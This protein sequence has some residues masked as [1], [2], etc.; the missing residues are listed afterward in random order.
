MI[1]GK[2][3]ER[4]IQY[5]EKNKNSVNKYVLPLQYNS[6][7]FVKAVDEYLIERIA[8]DGCEDDFVIALFIRILFLAKG[9]PHQTEVENGVKRIIMTGFPFWLSKGERHNC[10]WS[11]NHLACY[12]SIW[13]L[14]CQYN[15]IPMD[16]LESPA[17]YLDKYLKLKLK[18]GFFECVSQVYN[19][20]T[21]SALLNI[22]DFAID[23]KIRSNA[24]TCIQMLTNHF[25]QVS[26]PVDGSIYCAAGR[27]YQRYKVDC[28]GKNIN[29]Y[30]WILTG[31]PTNES[32]L[33]P[34]GS[35]F[36]SSTFIPT[37]DPNPNPTMTS[38]SVGA[39][40]KF[41]SEFGKAHG[42]FKMMNIWS[43]GNYFNADY[44][45]ETMKTIKTF[46]LWNHAHFKMDEY[47][48]LFQL[49][50]LS[51]LGTVVDNLD[52]F[53][54]GSDL[55]NVKYNIYNT[56]DYCLTSLENYNRGKMGAQ[57]C[58]WMANVGGVPVFTQAG[59]IAA[60][61]G[62]TELHET[63]AN[64]HLPGVYQKRNV[65][66][67]MYQPFDMLKK[68]FSDLAVYLYWDAS[69]FDETTVSA[70]KR[71]LF[72]CKGNSYIG[73]YST[74]MNDGYVN[75]NENQQGWVVILGNKLAYDSFA[76]FVTDVTNNA[77][78]SFSLKKTK[79]VLNMLGTVDT[80]Y[81]GI[82][83]Y[84]DIVIDVKW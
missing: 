33:S 4:K 60:S 75:K 49:V 3:E 82:V 9:K 80:Y 52:A 65:A 42:V 17:A 37:I 29:K 56:G 20:Y 50:P 13:Y 21:M 2:V 79:S 62:A 43:S 44:V 7:I 30:M 51:S 10:Y 67:I 6:E 31:K 81:Q 73:V 71:W 14:W 61:L 66:L 32:D 40:L 39:G 59:K 24:A 41:D 23:P 36:A 47:K 15:N 53:V 11:E 26:L 77:K 5:I 1:D 63:I 54:E 58:P 45:D 76:K 16:S 34:L 74:E 70:N 72:A 25:L 35:F 55:R 68:A 83:K 64:T 48:P 69:R 46:D 22:Y 38:I 84:N 19:A 8:K 78:I 12:L 18:Y 57:Q 27:T 28:S